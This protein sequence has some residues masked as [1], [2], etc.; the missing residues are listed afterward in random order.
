MASKFLKVK[1]DC[2]NEQVIFEKAAGTVRC[3]VC[4]AVLAEA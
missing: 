1:C 2:K 4:D 3:N